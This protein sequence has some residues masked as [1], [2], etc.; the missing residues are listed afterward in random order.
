[1]YPLKFYS[2]YFEKIWGGRQLEAYKD[3]MPAGNIG[4]SWDVACHEDGTSI[5]A[6]GSYKDMPLDKLIE[7][8]GNEVVGTKIDKDRFP[9]LLKLINSND[10]LSIQVHPDDEY[11]YRVEKDSGKTEAW[12]VVDAKEGA[13]LIVG[14]KSGCTREQFKKAIEEGN[15]EQYMNKVKIKKGDTYFIKSGLMH[16]ICE[17]AIIAEIQQNSNTTYRVY[18][19][20]RG[21]EL[22]VDKALDVVDFNLRGNKREGL[23]VEREGYSK[24]YLCLAKEFSLEKYEVSKEFTESSDLE[25]FYIFTCVEGYGTLSYKDGFESIKRGESVLIPAALGEYSFKGNMVLLKSYVPDLEK[26]ENEILQVIKG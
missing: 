12:Y 5:I 1:M 13:E 15:L 23:K 20:N 6:N 3:D 2:I 21:R 4:E 19:Y 18:D 24:T 11:G 25:R 16:A 9:L 26:V 22:H 8:K 14:V 17:G 10:K 7:E